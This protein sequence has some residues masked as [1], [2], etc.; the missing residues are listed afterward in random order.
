MCKLEGALPMSV[1]VKKKMEEV[2]CGYCHKATLRFLWSL[3]KELFVFYREE[4][5]KQIENSQRKRC[6]YC[7][8]AGTTA[9]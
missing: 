4:V 3:G 1:C 6:K 9:R 5:K 7:N 8:K 2:I